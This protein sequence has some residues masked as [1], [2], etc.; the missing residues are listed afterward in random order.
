MHN[1]A[2]LFVSIGTNPAYPAMARLAVQSAREAGAFNGAIVMLTDHPEHLAD[3]DLTVVEIDGAAHCAR[4][5]ALSRVNRHWAE[6]LRAFADL[7]H[8][9]AQYDR[10][11]YLDTDILCA[12]PVG[13]VIEAIG[14]DYLHFAYAPCAGW[15]D[16]NA[17]ALDHHSPFLRKG[18]DTTVLDSSPIAQGSLTGVCSGSYGMAGDRVSQFMQLWRELLLACFD[19]GEEVTDQ[20]ALNE[21]LLGGSIPG[22][23]LP[24]EMV[25]YPLWALMGRAERRELPANPVPVLYHFNPLSAEKKLG[26]MRAF[27]AFGPEALA[28]NASQTA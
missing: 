9:F 28:A 26:Y 16:S 5:P 20:M 3:L 2:L 13:P 18:A 8:D 4:F 6:N 27:Q 7:Y 25:A 11:L 12:G 14:T 10:V 15:L 1:D 23:A 17:I 21:C 19:R 22:L 24:N